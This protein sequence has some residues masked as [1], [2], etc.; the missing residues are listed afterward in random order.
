MIQVYKDNR[1]NAVF[2]CAACIHLHRENIPTFMG[3]LETTNLKVRS[4]DE[5]LKDPCVWSM[6]Q[7]FVVTYVKVTGPY[8]KLPANQLSDLGPVYPATGRLCGA[9]AGVSEDILRMDDKPLFHE[10][11]PN[12]DTDSPLLKA[13]LCQPADIEMFRHC[14]VCILKLKGI[15]L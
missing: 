15:N 9:L 6:A 5:D 12:V 2:E 8:W 11:P 3:M 1:F 10:C 14:L 13:A 4:V 7:A